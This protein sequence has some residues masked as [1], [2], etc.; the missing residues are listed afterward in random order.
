MQNRGHLVHGIQRLLKLLLLLEPLL[1]VLIPGCNTTDPETKVRYKTKI[2][3]VT[4]QIKPQ[5]FNL[6]EAENKNKIH[7]SDFAPA[8]RRFDASRNLLPESR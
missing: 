8:L 7:A 5:L 6:K 3:D 1:L 4:R 2:H